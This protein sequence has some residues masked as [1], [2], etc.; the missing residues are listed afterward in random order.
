MWMWPSLDA[1]IRAVQL[2]LKKIQ[3]GT[4]QN[5][6]QHSKVWNTLTWIYIPNDCP[7][8]H[9]VSHAKLLWN[10]VEAVF[11]TLPVCVRTATYVRTITCLS[12]DCHQPE[13]GFSPAWIRT[14]TCL[15]QDCHLPVSGITEQRT[16]SQVLVEAPPRT[17]HHT[18]FVERREADH[19]KPRGQFCS[20]YVTQIKASVTQC[21]DTCMQY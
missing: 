5:K 18:L 15:R 1:D 9:D 13:S 4:F 11:K 3:N 7:N 12:Q 20:Y 21:E 14:A 6:K 10:N 17:S 2:S 19:H 16:V 8:W